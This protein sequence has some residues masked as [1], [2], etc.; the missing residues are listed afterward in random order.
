MENESN[1]NEMFHSTGFLVVRDFF[2]T[3]SLYEYSNELSKKSRIGDHQI[4]NSPVA[5]RDPVME[6]IL[7]KVSPKVE[8]P[9]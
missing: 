3:K 2:E 7:I 6:E 8:S 5:Y 1:T 4:P 9:Y